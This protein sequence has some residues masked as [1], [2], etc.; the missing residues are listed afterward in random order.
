MSIVSSNK[1]ISTSLHGN[2]WPKERYRSRLRVTTR[3]RLGCSKSQ[4]CKQ[5][6]FSASLELIPW[7]GGNI[8]VLK[9][10]EMCW[11]CWTALQTL[12]TCHSWGQQA[13]MDAWLLK[14][15]G[16]TEKRGT[17]SD[18]HAAC[19]EYQSEKSV[20]QLRWEFHPPQASFIMGWCFDEV[21]DVDGWA[22]LVG[23]T[24]TAVNVP[25]KIAESRRCVFARTTQSHLT[26]A[27]RSSRNWRELESS[28]TRS[29][30]I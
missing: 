5:S 13:D 8:Q 10:V 6:S 21:D 23:V 24:F 11:T 3:W 9:C 30:A 18:P 17:Y 2:S 15:K 26:K 4:C 12:R 29:L 7:S 27:L 19:L 14:G 22:A 1:L 16:K 25:G 28:G 20:I